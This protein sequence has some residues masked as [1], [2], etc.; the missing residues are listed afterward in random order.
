MTRLKF[1]SRICRRAALALGPLFGLALPMLALPLQAQE[2]SDLVRVELLAEPAA[3][4]PGEPFTVGI[5][6]TMKEHWHTYWRNPGDSGEP[7]TVTWKL[8][9]G[10][11]AGELEWPA[12]SPIRLGPVTSFGYE[13]EAILLARITPPRDLPTSNTIVLDADVAFLVCEKVCIPGED[14]VSVS[15]P[16]SDAGG[17]SPRQTLFDGARAKLPQPRQ[18]L[19]QEFSS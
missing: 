7:T 10:F 11:S 15:L 16:V 18:H 13:G 9:P 1:L 14:K 5:R 2:A 4:K 6:L 12:P 8:P 3:I 17:P 19:R